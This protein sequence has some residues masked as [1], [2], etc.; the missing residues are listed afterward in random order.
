MQID[1]S[2]L[3]PEGHR[4]DEAFDPAALAG[5]ERGRS[6]VRVTPIRVELRGWVRPEGRLVRASGELEA[7]VEAECDRC[8]RPVVVRVASEF[9]Q[10][11]A[12][13]GADPSRARGVR[14]EEIA[15]TEPELDL[16]KLEG[17]VLDTRELAREQLELATPIRTICA[18]ACAGLCPTC[19]ADLNAGPCGCA[20]T[21]VDPRW[22]ALRRMMSDE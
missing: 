9:D 2:Q 21:E 4:I 16:A 22:D 15:L 20:E 17:S 11:Y 5:P 6:E 12:W 7:E 18:E 3:E 13:E 10:R 8:L 14:G 19:G 1:L